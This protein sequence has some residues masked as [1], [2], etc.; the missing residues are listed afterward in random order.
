MRTLMMTLAAL[1]ATAAAAP[2]AAQYYPDDRAS[3]GYRYDRGYDQGY[4]RNS[5]QQLGWR[6]DRGIR[7]GSIS[8]REAYGLRRE[9]NQLT[10]LDRR[11]RQGGLTRWERTELDRRT[12]A[13]ARRVR[14]ERNDGGWRNDN[15]YGNDQW[16]D[17]NRGDGR[18]YDRR[19]DD[20]NDNDRYDD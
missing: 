1:S 12:D 5:L 19:G 7:N 18:H 4:N 11:L 6:I 17:R 8:G 2:A 3:Q 14:F 20:D 9:L 10:V 16:R 13:L 15:G